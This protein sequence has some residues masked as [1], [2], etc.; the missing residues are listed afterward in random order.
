MHPQKETARYVV[1]EKQAP[2]LF[3]VKDNQPT[4]KADIAGLQLEAFPP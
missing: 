3:T 2:D 1:E 4:L